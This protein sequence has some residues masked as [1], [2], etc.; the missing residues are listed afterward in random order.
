MKVG[1]IVT[2]SNDNT[3]IQIGE[4]WIVYR[5]KKGY[6]FYDILLSERNVPLEYIYTPINNNINNNII[7]KGDV[8][9]YKK[10][11][12]MYEA[13]VNLVDWASSSAQIRIIQ[14]NLYLNH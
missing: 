11:G 12:R 3:A 7:V 14:R 6:E 4:I 9:I 1:D 5:D 10:R 8:I 2:V 13:L